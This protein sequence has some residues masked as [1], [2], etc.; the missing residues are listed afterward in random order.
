MCCLRKWSNLLKTIITQSKDRASRWERRGVQSSCADI[1]W[2]T[3]DPR[4][5]DERTIKAVWW[6]Y[7]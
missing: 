1:P 3:R 4:W 2:I 6:P 5:A 7:W